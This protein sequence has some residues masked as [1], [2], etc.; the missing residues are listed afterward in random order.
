MLQRRQGEV[1]Y[2][3]RGAKSDAYAGR[4]VSE[5]SIHWFI[6]PHLFCFLKISERDGLKIMEK[7]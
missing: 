5:E 6:S 7:F 2:L 3:I 4:L 1:E